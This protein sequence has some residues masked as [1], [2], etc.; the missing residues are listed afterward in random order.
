MTSQ[1]SSVVSIIIT[2]LLS[3]YRV[4][5][6]VQDTP[7]GRPLNPSALQEAVYLS[8]QPWAARNPDHIFEN[9]WSYL[10]SKLQYRET[11]GLLSVGLEAL[12]N[13]FL[14]AFHGHLYV[15]REK[16]SAWQQSILSRICGT[17]IIAAASNSY[18]LRNGQEELVQ[19]P[20]DS[21]L[22]PVATTWPDK[23][24]PILYPYDPLVEDYII[25]TGLHETH[26]HL[27]GSTHA[28]QCW[29]RALHSP[30]A[31][32]WDFN[33]KWTNKNKHE[34]E[35]IRELARAINPSFSPSEL[36]RQLIAAAQLRTWL[37]AAAYD[38]LDPS[39]I[40]PYSYD[41]IS[42]VK[43]D[44]VQLDDR[45]GQLKSGSSANDEIRWQ[46]LILRRLAHTPSIQLERMMHCYLL[47]QNH[48]YRL[49]V[50]SEEQFGFDQFQKITYT[51]LREPAEKSYLYRFLSMHGKNQQFSRTGYLEGRFAPKT[52]SE[53]NARLLYAIL[54]GYWSYRNVVSKRKEQTKKPRPRTL[55]ELLNS[56]NDLV[57]T[58]SP[59]DRGYHRLALVAHFLKKSWSSLPSSE[60]GPYRF[61]RLRKDL[62]NSTNALL[63]TMIK[64]PLLSTWV[65]GIDAAAN[66][67]HAPPEIFSSYFRVCRSA[68][69]SRCTYHVGEDFPHL[70]TGLRHMLDAIELLDLRAGDRIGHGTAMGISPQLWLDRIPERLIVKKGDWMLDLL[71]GWT[72]LRDLPEAQVTVNRITYRLAEM[73]SNIFGRDISCSAL[74]RAM[75]F[76]HLNVEYL[77]ASYESSDI[78]PPTSFNALWQSET[79]RVYAARRDNS[80]DLNLLW[81]WLSDKKLW[82][83]S[84]ELIEV[85]ADHFDAGTYIFIQQ[86]LM[87]KIAERGI[88]IETLPSSNVRI[89]HYHSFNEHH[90]LRWM[91]VPGHLH[92]GDPEIMVS[93]GSDDP[94]IF[95]GD[96]NSEFYQLY[97]ALRN[98]DIGDEA[99]LS[100]LKQLN[101][102]GQKYR[103]HHSSLG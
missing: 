18:L 79:E 28:E 19:H 64:W 51:D 57:A 70:L 9:G 48:Y 102:R 23:I 49:L 6:V 52:T 13:E 39:T 60:S 33:N 67:L 88:I 81:Q 41:R 100:Y 65:R 8:Y 69:L 1:S 54:M 50:Q 90:A 66:E 16:F 74:E 59:L 91:R 78:F 12:S 30:K 44:G 3:N 94:G 21:S 82:E 56:L 34:L 80:S 73:A 24:V 72:L 2:A 92:D 46:Q 36:Y 61:F 42:A 35:K 7:F 75:S 27:N 14:D 96:L 47:L 5:K 53:K 93:M 76:R 89:S 86:A 15:K 20:H 85:S 26:L 63:N 101:E 68:G 38:Y 71:A 83:R 84:E 95:A 103:F 29:L 17:P 32:T 62:K 58:Q 99:S 10:I 87:K 31:E 4:L 11:S 77:Q 40:L 22:V 25:R 45:R 98:Q 43:A 97:S 55:T 37:V